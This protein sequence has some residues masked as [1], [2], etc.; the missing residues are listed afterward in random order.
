MKFLQNEHGYFLSSLLLF[1]TVE[2]DDGRDDLSSVIE[3]SLLEDHFALNSFPIHFI[4]LTRRLLR[5][6]MDLL[7]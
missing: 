4:T 1:S 2:S 3:N 7:L 5:E 6:E